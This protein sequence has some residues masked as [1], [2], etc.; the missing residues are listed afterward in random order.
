M[1]GEYPQTSLSEERQH[2]PKPTK[3]SGHWTMARRPDRSTGTI[4]AA[5][6]Y[7]HDP[8]TW[9]K[10]ARSVALCE[11]VTSSGLPIAQVCAYHLLRVTRGLKA[12]KETLGR[13]FGYRAR[14]QGVVQGGTLEEDWL[15][16]I[17][18]ASRL[19]FQEAFGI[20]VAEQYEAEEFYSLL[21]PPQGWIFEELEW[22]D[23][24]VVGPN[25][26]TW[27]N[28]ESRMRITPERDLR[29]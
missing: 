8:V 10:Y 18:E 22:Q 26:A 27:L 24:A 4:L 14:Q 15:A 17:T 29:L 1:G 25:E 28:P 11:A 7:F 6:R 16:P 9:C 3:R 21:G 2:W 23:A 19:S 12:M 5:G 20:T 13:E